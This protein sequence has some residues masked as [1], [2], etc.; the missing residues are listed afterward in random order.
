MLG[1]PMTIR[2]PPGHLTQTSGIHP[3]CRWACTSSVPRRHRFQLRFRAF[4]SS[5]RLLPPA[6]L[7][8]LSVGGSLHDPG[9]VGLRRGR[10]AS[11][12]V[13]SSACLSLFRA[14]GDCAFW[15]L[16]W[17][18]APNQ[19]FQR[20]KSQRSLPCQRVRW[21]RLTFSDLDFV[22]GWRANKKH[23]RRI[24]FVPG[25]LKACS[26]TRKQEIRR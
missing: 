26:P 4:R 13:W 18:G 12:A 1:T 24:L 23:C 14:D 6:A 2:L 3:F 22:T 10:E 17:L 7:P 8:A 9:P 19:H 21:K 5:A 11:L 25:C 20:I 15:G 16:T